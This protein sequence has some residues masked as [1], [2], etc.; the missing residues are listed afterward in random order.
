MATQC[1][2]LAHLRQQ[3]C[4]CMSGSAGPEAGEG[5]AALPTGALRPVCAL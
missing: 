5:P 2:I 4:M 1:L 3:M